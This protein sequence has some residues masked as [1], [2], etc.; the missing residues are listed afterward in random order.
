MLTSDTIG[1]E[2]ECNRER[3]SVIQAWEL[4]GALNRALPALHRLRREGRFTK[5]AAT[6]QQLAELQ[7]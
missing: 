1:Q 5:S 4:S 6:R 2:E 3:E 7:R